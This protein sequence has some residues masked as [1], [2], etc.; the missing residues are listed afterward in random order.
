MAAFIAP[1]SAGAAVARRAAEASPAD[2][3]L[4]A[5]VFPAPVPAVPHYPEFLHSAPASWLADN[6]DA[7]RYGLW[8]VLFVIVALSLHRIFFSSSVR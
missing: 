4:S 6:A 3:S 8:A 5:P 7:L 2:V 1:L